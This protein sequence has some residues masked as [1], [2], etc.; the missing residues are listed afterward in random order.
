M[1]V[2]IG[3]TEPNVLLLL[4]LKGELLAAEPKAE[5]P[6]VPKA[7]VAGLAPNKL[8]PVPVF[9]EPKTPPVLEAAGAPNAEVCPV[10]PKADVVWLLEPNNP[11]PVLAL[12]PKAPE[13]ELFPKGEGVLL[14]PLLAGL[15]KILPP[16]LVLLL[17]PPNGEVLL[18]KGDVLLVLLEAPKPPKPELPDPLWNMAWPN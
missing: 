17:T 2:E 1:E 10:D 18:P 4:E 5:D 3:L 11:P 7:E 15:P 12:E 9:R 14:G 8:D 6:E 13:A 16:A